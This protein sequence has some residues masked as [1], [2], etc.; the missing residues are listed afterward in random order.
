MESNRPA[1]T[2]T[3]LLALVSVYVI[4]G[5]TYLAMRTA[6]AGFPPMLMASAAQMLAGGIVVLVTGLAMGERI[7]R[8]PSGQWISCLTVLSKVDILRLL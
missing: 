8:I 4:W 3:V 5:S 6:L 7:P 1:L 2:P